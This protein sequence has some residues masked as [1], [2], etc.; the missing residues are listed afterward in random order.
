MKKSFHSPKIWED[1]AILQSLW[2]FSEGVTHSDNL[3]DT[4]TYNTEINIFMSGSSPTPF[5]PY[6]TDFELLQAVMIKIETTPIDDITNNRLG[7]FVYPNK[8]FIAVLED[9]KEA[10]VSAS[11]PIPTVLPVLQ[12]TRTQPGI[13]KSLYVLVGLYCKWYV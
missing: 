10:P 7:I 4:E 9:E 2:V 5:I 3:I 1:A 11:L 6:K 8:V 12:V 13:H